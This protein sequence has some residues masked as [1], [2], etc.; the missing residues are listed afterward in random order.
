MRGSDTSAFAGKR[1][2]AAPAGLTRT[3]TRPA[4]G[5]PC[6]ESFHASRCTSARRAAVEIG[7][8]VKVPSTATPLERRLYPP[9]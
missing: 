1:L 7:L 4:V 9:A 2:K 3:L 8:L 6:N 5:R